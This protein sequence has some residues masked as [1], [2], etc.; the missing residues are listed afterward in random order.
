MKKRIRF[1]FESDED[2][3]KE[4]LTIQFMKKFKQNIF[5]L[6][7]PSID[8]KLPLICYLTENIGISTP[9]IEYDIM[10]EYEMPHNNYDICDWIYVQTQSNNVQLHINNLEPIDFLKLNFNTFVLSMQLYLI[11]MSFCKVKIVCDESFNIRTTGIY[12]PKSARI[13]FSTN[14]QKMSYKNIEYAMHDG[15]IHAQ[16]RFQ[17]K[18]LKE[19]Q[20]T[21]LV[22]RNKN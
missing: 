11:S 1:F 15:L 17:K 10:G 4:Q 8:K 9:I 20:T 16:N 6:N 2:F 3:F 19:I 18:L 7:V 21:N 22:L 5:C 13:W 14:E 12:L